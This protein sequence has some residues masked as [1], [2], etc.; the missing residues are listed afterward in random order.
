MTQRDWGMQATVG[1]GRRLAFPQG[2]AAGGGSAVNA[3]LALRPLPDD[4]DG[5]AGS[6]NPGWGWAD[7]LPC[8]VRLE[9]DPV[10]AAALPQSHGTGGPIPIVRWRADEFTAQQQAFF[11]GCR[12]I[13]LDAV[14]DHNDGTASGVGPFPMNRRHGERISTA[15][16]YLE[17]IRDRPNLTVRGGVLVD[18]VVVRGG[19]ATGVSLIAN[20]SPHDIGADRVVISAG[21]I[22]SPAILARSGLAAASGRM[23]RSL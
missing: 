9:D 16:G 15:I 23:E 20:G 8:L 22:H 1:P 4:L 11:D 10:G 3:A 19:R 12:S 21:A 17:A 18:R 6:G 2:K 14:A 13:G 5:W 7:M